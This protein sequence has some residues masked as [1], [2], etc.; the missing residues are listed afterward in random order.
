M[1]KFSSRALREGSAFALVVLLLLALPGTSSAVVRDGRVEDAPGL[2]FEN[3]VYNWNHIFIDIVNMTNS[4]V[5]FGGAVT[6]LD[7][8]GY[9]LATVRLLPKKVA[10]N[11]VERYTAYCVRG[12]G[13]AA[14]KA[15]RVVWDFSPY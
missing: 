2:R 3:V 13:E 10:R 12:S 4:S 9:P 5:S 15:V 7:R 11:S 14:R 1:V 6:F 8:Q